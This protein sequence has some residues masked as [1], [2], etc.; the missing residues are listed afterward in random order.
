MAFH[1]HFRLLLALIGVETS[2][3]SALAAEPCS[4][5]SVELTETTGVNSGLLSANSFLDSNRGMSI[6]LRETIPL[7]LGY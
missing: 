4:F 3:F 5:N 6:A 2:L 7:L 1:L